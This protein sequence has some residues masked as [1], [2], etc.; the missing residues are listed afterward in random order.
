[1]IEIIREED[2]EPTKEKVLPKDIKQIGKPDI[3]DRIYVEDRVYRYLHPYDE[4]LEKA[5]YVLL[6]RFENFT[7]RQCTFIEG[8][9]RLEEMNFDGELPQWNDNTWGYIYKKLK[10]DYD[11]MVI[12]GWAMDIK[13]QLPNLTA[14]IER[15]HQNHFGGIHQVL[16]LMDSLEQEE[17]F[18]SSRNNHLYRRDG[19]YIYYGRGIPAILDYQ[20]EKSPAPQESPREDAFVFETETPAQKQRDLDLEEKIYFEQSSLEEP[21]REQK[22]SFD[23]GRTERREFFGG[24]EKRK[25]FFGGE[26]KPREGSYRKQLAGEEA[27]EKVPSFTPSLVLLAVVFVL[28]FAAYQNHQ[29]MNDMQNALAQMNQQTA[30]TEE[31]TA[32]TAKEVKVEQVEG[33][34]EKQN[35]A[36]TAGQNAEGVQTADGETGAADEQA[37]ASPE[38]AANTADAAGTG[39]ETN[40]SAGGTDTAS[41][42]TNVSAGGTDTASA[43]TT[44]ASAGSG[45]GT[46][47]TGADTSAGA[48]GTSAGT[49]ANTSAGTGEKGGAA[50]SSGNEN[51]SSETGAAGTS[52]GDGTSA[53]TENG[54]GDTTAASTEA[55][56]Y[57]KQ[58]Y[59]IVQKGDSLAAICRKIYQTTAMMDEVCKANNIEDPNDI[60]AGQYLTLPN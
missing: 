35:A 10:K 39:A 48:T 49:G 53:G 26:Q 34:V 57:L 4:Q 5:A 25:E 42:E 8:A 56:T 7:G 19:F 6:G 22:T 21:E 24:G 47:E 40:A 17:A 12:V 16:F 55:Q 54:T 46:T 37:A 14:R 15:L 1:M 30:S 20:E 45:A 3:G 38:N 31:Q 27:K 33:N 41:A 28:G 11:D 58:G 43:G 29:K 36:E 60:Y 44:E 13:G 9:I 32:E 18:Y 23:S 52:G 51:G 2:Y 59:Y 50:D